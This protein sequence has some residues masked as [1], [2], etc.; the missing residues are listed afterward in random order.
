[1][2]RKLNV[3][4]PYFDGE[5]ICT[6]LVNLKIVMVICTIILCHNM[7][8][9]CFVGGSR[10]MLLTQ[11]TGTWRSLTTGWCHIK[12]SSISLLSV[13][14]LV[15]WN[16]SY[17]SIKQKLVIQVC[18]AS[19]PGRVGRE[20]R[21]GIDCLRMRDHSQKNLGI[22]LCLEIVNKINTYTFDIFLYHRKIQ[23]FASWITFNSMNVEDNAMERKAKMLS[24]G[25]QLVSVIQYTTRG[26][27]LHAWP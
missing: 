11:L 13:P 22:H 2:Y 8:T 14:I 7:S 15:W 10:A 26:C 3:I 20:R 19:Y 6:Y 5:C 17:V 25:Y 24:C 18:I 12:Y 9:K 1:M 21:H 16:T 4:T 23:P 27:H